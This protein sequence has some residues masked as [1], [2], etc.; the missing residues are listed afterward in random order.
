MTKDRRGGGATWEDK[1]M[2]V[3]LKVAFIN[4]E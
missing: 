4:M 2:A 1:V 3:L